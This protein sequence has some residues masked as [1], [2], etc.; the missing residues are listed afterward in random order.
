VDFFMLSLLKNG[1]FGCNKPGLLPGK[2]RFT[3]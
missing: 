3:L 2:V 1:F